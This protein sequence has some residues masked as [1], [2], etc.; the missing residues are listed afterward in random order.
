MENGDKLAGAEFRD[1]FVSQ[2]KRIK[3]RIMLLTGGRPPADTGTD[4]DVNVDVPQEL[5][6]NEGFSGEFAPELVL[7]AKDDEGANTIVKK[8]NGNVKTNLMHAVKEYDSNAS[9]GIQMNCGKNGSF[10][11]CVSRK[12]SISH[13][14]SQQDELPSFQ[15]LTDFPNQTAGDTRQVF[16]TEDS[17]V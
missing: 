9:R 15:I 5:E 1:R 10:I 7:F 11:S 12:G 17:P 8:L 16:M 3:D 2:G 14:T 6:Y 13:Q 4:H